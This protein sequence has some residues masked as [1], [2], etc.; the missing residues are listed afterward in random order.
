MAKIFWTG[1]EK[2][3]LLRLAGWGLEAA[4]LHLLWLLVRMMSPDRASAVGGRVMRWIG[5]RSRKHRHVLANLRT[6]FPAKSEQEIQMLAVRSWGNLGSVLAE[7]VHL[8]RITADNPDD[9]YIEVVHERDD[10]E[11]LRSRPCI[12]V[13]AHVANWELVAFVGQQVCGS[14]DV[15]YSPQN[16]LFLER[17]VQRIRAPLRCGFYGK[18]NA[19]RAMYALLRKGRS[20]GLLADVRVDGGTRVPFYGVDAES[21]TT[22]AWLSLKT[23]CDIV[24]VRVERV[25]DA[26]FRVTV[27][28]PLRTV[29]GDEPAEQ[30]IFRTTLE[31]NHL[32]ESWINER[33][34]QWLC[35]K[36]RW[37]KQ[38]MQEAG[39]YKVSEA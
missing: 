24:P 10:P 1:K 37:P 14:L 11:S 3:N 17:M 30:A 33:P 36:R 5:P 18:V 31:L 39:A 6:A 22:P 16:N 15:I 7:F 38:A 19:V 34:E 9:P 27:C 23:G 26:H 25:R 29:Q 12:I 28:K 32:I 13:T 35:T 2:S 21:T 8:D 4:M 20:V